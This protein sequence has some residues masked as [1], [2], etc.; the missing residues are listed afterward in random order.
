MK[1]PKQILLI[2]L[3]NGWLGALHPFSAEEPNLQG[4]VFVS[5]FKNGHDTRQGIPSANIVIDPYFWEAL[6]RGLYWKHD[7]RKPVEF[8][9]IHQNGLKTFNYAQPLHDW[10]I[11]AHQ[12]L[13]LILTGA[14]SV[15][16]EEF[17]E[18]VLETKGEE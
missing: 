10:Q 3:A 11:T 17:W 7:N 15:K 14:P 8:L 1:I 4:Y 5:Y 9:K 18:D 16:W 2:A 6:G 12:C 13:H